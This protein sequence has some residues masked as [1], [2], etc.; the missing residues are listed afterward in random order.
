MSRVITRVLISERKVSQSQ[1]GTEEICIDAI[2][3]FKDERKPWAKQCGRPLEPGKGKETDSPLVSQRGMQPCQH[4]DVS[5]LRSISDF[6]PSD[7]KIINL[8]F[9][10]PL[11]LC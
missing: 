11:N 9:F 6:Q 7:C 3:G 8:C 2:A 1:G 4:L 5:P 10:K